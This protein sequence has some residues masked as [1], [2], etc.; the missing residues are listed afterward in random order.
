MQ[1][2]YASW[3]E[4]GQGYVVGHTNYRKGQGDDAERIATMQA[5]KMRTIAELSAGVWAQFPL[6]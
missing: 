2:A 5:S 4:Y 6:R 1:G 3:Q